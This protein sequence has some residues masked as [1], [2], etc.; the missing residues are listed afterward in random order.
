MNLRRH[1]ARFWIW[2]G[3]APLIAFGLLALLFVLT[4]LDVA[5]A[6]DWAW[7]AGAG[8]WLG[9]GSWW[10]DDL[11]HRGG[12]DLFIGI[13]VVLGAVVAVG[14]VWGRWRPW[15]R[16]AAFLL[17]SMAL[18]W[19]LVG[20]LKQVTNVD[21]PVDLRGFGGD[22]PYARVWDPRPAGLPRGRCFPG[23]HAASG[24]TLFAFY[25][26]LRER[27]PRR[28]R[29]LLLL[30]V[31]VGG[32]FAF[33]QEARGAHFL[34]HDVTSAFL[35]WFVCLGTYL[36]WPRGTTVEEPVTL[37]AFPRQSSPRGARSPEPAGTR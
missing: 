37:R 32:V 6:R 23:S 15:R 10:A 20:G 7:D 14:S 4:P 25:F 11:I 34:S 33:A 29:A 22:R 3:I 31:L 5:L 8:R 21:C 36:V 17:M 24:F 27:R 30:A 12:R 1:D 35:V 28:A 19:G 18:G 13:A 16:G 9:R 2:H 26:L